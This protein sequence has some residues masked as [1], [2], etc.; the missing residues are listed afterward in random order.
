MTHRIALIAV[1]LLLLAGA[2][3][4]QDLPPVPEGGLLHQRSHD[5]TDNA[6]G[7]VGECFISVDRNDNVYMTFLQNESVQFI[8]KIVDGGYEELYMRDSFNSF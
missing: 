8:R 5:C 6:S 4:A 2:L 1:G 7:E 3:A